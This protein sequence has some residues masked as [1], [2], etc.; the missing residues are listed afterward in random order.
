MAKSRAGRPWRRMVAYILR[1]DGYVCQLRLPGCTGVAETADHII[2][3]AV[4]PDL[5][6]E[7]SNLQAACTWCNQHRGSRHVPAAQPPTPSPRWGL[8]QETPR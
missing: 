4:R 3:F 5:E 6:L 8:T 1:R 2:P 7:P